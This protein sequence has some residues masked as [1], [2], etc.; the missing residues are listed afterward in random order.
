MDDSFR[1]G[2]GQHHGCL[3]TDLVS[4]YEELLLQLNVSEIRNM[5]H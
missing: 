1:D 4:W 2:E 3:V 5:M